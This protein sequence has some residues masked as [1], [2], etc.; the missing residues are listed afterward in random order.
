M[1]MIDIGMFAHNEED[2]IIATLDRFVSQSIFHI[3]NINIRLT[4]LANGCTD[5]TQE[6]CYQFFSDL[7]IPNFQLNAMQ[8]SGKSRTWNKF[9]HDISRKEAEYLIFCDADI[10]LMDPC[11]LERL[12]LFVK[13]RPQLIASSSRP[14][15]DLAFKEKNTMVE[16]IILRS[17]S[18]LDDWKK[19]ICGQLYVLRSTSA[20]RI[21]LP[22]GL[23]VEDGFVRA[24]IL[25]NNFTEQEN[26]S[27]IDGSDDIFHIYESE[28]SLCQIIRHQ[29]RIVIGSAINILI[30]QNILRQAPQRREE[31]LRDISYENEWLNETLKSQ[32]PQSPFGFVPFHF[33]FKRISH[34][35]NKKTKFSPIAILILLCG[36]SFDLIVYVI[37]Q[38]KMSRGHG[39]NYW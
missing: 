20:R 12:I 25:T 27:V 34:F 29:T 38:I 16:K 1:T 7:N 21:W 17:A 24:M 22:A 33:A 28:T 6:I 15:K 5:K 35:F 31:Y 32:L 2:N 14:V 10:E 23:P 4:V 36:L 30:F 11:T 8:E 9:V 26:F 13:H 3:A 19:A 37:A 39:A 18:G